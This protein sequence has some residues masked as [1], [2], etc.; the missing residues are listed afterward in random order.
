M[1][2]RRNYINK[3]KAQSNKV[4]CSIIYISLFIIVFQISG[5]KPKITQK[6]YE[7][8]DSGV[9]LI[10]PSNWDLSY[11]ERSGV[12][13]VET[14]KQL[15][16]S[17]SARIEVFGS[18]C[19]IATPWENSSIDE[20]DKNINRIRL[21]YGLDTITSIQEPE[22]SEKGDYEITNVII[23]VPTISMSQDKNRIQVSQKYSDT[24]QIIEIVA[25]SHLNSK[26]FMMAYI[27]YGDNDQINAQAKEIYNSII[28]FCPSE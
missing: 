25:K 20:I 14:Q 8:L 24:N 26:V 23:L 22:K 13:V 28:R 5:C 19:Q 11:D 16:D 1:D 27:Y 2:I 17:A 10:L 15:F 21:L 18:P 4:I 12:I 7:N 3:P 6:D 9:K